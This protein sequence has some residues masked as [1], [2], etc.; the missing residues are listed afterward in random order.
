MKD[1][2]PIQLTDTMMDTMVKMSEGNP[3]GLRVLLEVYSKDPLMILGLDDMNIRG[4]QIWVGYKDF[5]KCDLDLFIE[6]IKERSGDM[7]DI[8]NQEAIRGG[9]PVR[10]V[11]SGASFR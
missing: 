5:C 9:Y 8:I 4:W 10:A 2:K 7:V 1:R 3:G 6:K 11:T